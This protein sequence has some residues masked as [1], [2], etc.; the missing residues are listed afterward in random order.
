MWM[1]VEGSNL[2]EIGGQSGV[3]VHMGSLLFSEKRE[4]ESRHFSHQFFLRFLRGVQRQV[5]RRHL[6]AL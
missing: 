6:T 5:H 4:S 1:E 3:V 2:G